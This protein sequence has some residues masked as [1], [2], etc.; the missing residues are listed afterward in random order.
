MKEHLRES[1]ESDIVKTMLSPEDAKFVL[2]QRKSPIAIMARLRQ[3]VADLG[4][5]DLL[6]VPQH[7]ALEKTLSDLH[8]VI[9][10]C[11]RIQG[12]PIPSVY[13]AHASR[14]LM[15]SLFFLPLAL[16][17]T[18][19]A[20]LVTSLVGFA[21]LGLDEISHFLEEPFRLMPI[22]QLCKTSMLD[23]ADALVCQPGAL[24]TKFGD[25][26]MSVDLDGTFETEPAYW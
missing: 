19:T 11:Q 6:K 18:G 26:G 15:L 7:N 20:V 21:M 8:N 13:T 5:R 14:L 23:V 9:M 25:G 4:N 3:S 2:N 24:P 22:Y 16:H 1:D 17:G 10:V 12:S